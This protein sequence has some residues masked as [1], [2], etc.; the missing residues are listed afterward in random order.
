M[1][2]LL[3]HFIGIGG[4]SMSALA[5]YIKSC[6]YN[7]QGSDIHK[8]K[9]TDDL[10][11]LGIKVFFGHKKSNLS[12]VDVVIYNYAIKRD[13]VELKYSKENKIKTYS[14]GELL[15]LISQKY[16]NVISIAG[17]HG[18][19]S[20]TEMIYNCLLV[21]GM[22]PT[23]HIGGIIKGHSF[24]F[25]NGDKNYFIT[26]ACEYHDCFLNLKSKVGVV[27]NVEPEHLD[28]FKSFYN[29]KLSYKKYLEN[30]NLTIS[31]FDCSNKNNISF[32]FDNKNIIAKNVMNRKG[33]FSYDAY[34]NGKFFAHIDLGCYGQHSVI[35]SL[36]VIGVCVQLNVPKKYV[37]IGLCMPL[38][39][40]RRFE[41]IKKQPLVVH[42]YAHHPTEIKETIQ[43]FK[44][45]TNKKVLVVF[46]PH[47]YS[48][49]KTL[50]NEFLTCFDNV[51]MIYLIKTFPAREK[52]DK[53]ASAFALYKGLKFNGKN[54]KYFAS[55]SL[56]KEKIQEKA[57]Q[58][59][60]ILI[61]G[62]GDI[63]NLAYSL[64]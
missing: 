63:V 50:F 59:Y 64:K 43:T 7:V 11:R 47:T 24:G 3:F 4:I 32:G 53:S 22:N 38:N 39:I 51:D 54:C 8:S 33:K 34:I 13:N 61:L 30:S 15:G 19:T 52:P 14:R 31:N 21:A 60:D 36:A 26:E 18:K 44:N 46:Q 27:L 10:Q 17:S 48:R 20:T 40:Q 41:I 1:K 56:A 6:G 42:D 57:V 12:N 45:C 58:G 25:I 37:K 16:K 62:A 55:F 29:E 49:T 2:N 28:Y 5:F 9:I 23:L 35:N